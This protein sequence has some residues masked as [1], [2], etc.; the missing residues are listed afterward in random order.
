MLPRNVRF[1]RRYFVAVVFNAGTSRDPIKR[2]RVC[3]L[4][5]RGNEAYV[6]EPRLLR[7]GLL[8]VRLLRRCSL[9]AQLVHIQWH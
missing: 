3:D 5:R 6:I 7:D 9:Q 2:I 8:R 1:V 4:T